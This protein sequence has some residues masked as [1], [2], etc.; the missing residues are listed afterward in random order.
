MSNRT[1]VS[2]PVMDLL[3]DILRQAGLR[4]RVLD[5]RALTPAQAL[6]FPCDKSLGLHVALQGPV[7]IHSPGRAAPLV[8]QSGDIAIMARGHDH[9]V[10]TEP[11]LDKRRIATIFDQPTG[12][13]RPLTPIGRS[14]LISGAYQ[15][16][17]APIHPFLATLPDW[18]VLRGAELPRLGP[19]AL[20][21]GLVGEEAANA[22]P[23]AQTIL[24]G[25]LDVL[26]AY[27]LREIAA[28]NAEAGPGLGKALADA[29]VKQA[30][31][32]MHADYARGWTLEA[33]AEAVGLSRTR[34][35][36]RFRAAMDDTPLAYLRTVRMQAAMRLLSET[37][38]KLDDV[39]AQVGYQDAFGFSKVFK[40][41]VGIA[42]KEFRR[43]DLADRASPWRLTAS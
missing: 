21:V 18:F 2:S 27:L 3:T 13:V 16:W 36:E 31:A 39:A 41:T 17:N 5:L 1:D 38:K 37:D 9:V 4:H 30:I 20:T 19:I 35:A 23:G 34:L 6:R 32:L 40:R 8:L 43:R 33:L 7:Y 26:F 24:H 12:S 15:F 25:L 22:G 29:H 10:G 42:P 14:R 28:R 11:K